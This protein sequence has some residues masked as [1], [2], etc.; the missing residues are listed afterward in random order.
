MRLDLFKKEYEE[1][2]EKFS[3]HMN[4]IH[5]KIIEYF[6]SEL[7]TRKMIENKVSKLKKLI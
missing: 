7:K 2:K 3:D 5:S 4:L 1:E 6:N